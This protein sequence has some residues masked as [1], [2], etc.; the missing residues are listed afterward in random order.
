LL[1]RN[2]QLHRYLTSVAD[3]SRLPGRLTVIGARATVTGRT[4]AK[5]SLDFIWA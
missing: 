3:F 4:I 2:Q 5:V 1:A